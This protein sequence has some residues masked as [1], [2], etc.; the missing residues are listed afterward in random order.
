MDAVCLGAAARAAGVGRPTKMGRGR[1]WEGQRTHDGKRGAGSGTGTAARFRVTGGLELG[2]GPSSSA[3]GAFS[4]GA[5][6]PGAQKAA[7]SRV[8]RS[9]ST[10]RLPGIAPDHRRRR[11][12]STS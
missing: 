4:G 1:R 5:S 2:Q 10:L 8:G 7:T 9:Q 3:G 12:K 11:A 6:G